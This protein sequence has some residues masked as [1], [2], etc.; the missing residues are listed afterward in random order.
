M[1]KV[2]CS[3]GAFIG[4]ANGRDFKLLEKYIPEFSCDGFELMFYADWYGKADELTGFLCSLSAD[5]PVLHCDKTIGEELAR[6]NFDEAYRLFE[7][8]CKIA[9]KIGSKI[10]VLHLWNGLISDSNIEANFSA[11]P[12]LMKIAAEHGLVLTAENV[13]AREMTPLA[14]LRKL[15]TRCPEACFTYDTKMADFDNENVT[16]FSVENL[17]LWE[18]V[19]HIHLND[20]A[21]AYR[22]WNSIKALHP[23]DGQVDF[24]AFF[25][26]KKKVGYRGDYTIE[27]SVL[28]PD[29]RVD[30]E[31]MNRSVRWLRSALEDRG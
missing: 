4:R 26:G 23:T 25:D 13:L 10:L 6:E 21:G 27:A 9:E 22:D 7:I 8:N 11:Y 12:T 24:D 5:F 31:R 16:A 3:T 14:L 2:F 1:N 20:R 15:K 30:A 29:G 19:R 18:N 17:K 28:S